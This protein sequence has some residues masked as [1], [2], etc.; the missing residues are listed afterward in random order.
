MGN[1][2]RFCTS[3]LYISCKFWFH[4]VFLVSITATELWNF[5]KFLLQQKKIY[6]L[7]IIFATILFFKW[8]NFCVNKK[9]ASY[10]YD[11]SNAFLCKCV[12]LEK[13]K[14]CIKSNTRSDICSL[15]ILNSD[16]TTEMCNFTKFLLQQQTIFVFLT[17]MIFQMICLHL[18]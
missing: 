10:L 9:I 7:F 12:K 18:D 5:T 11:F 2:S 14:Y 8:N 17:Y 3:C 13:A 4:E 16:F 1:N 15:Y 6:Y